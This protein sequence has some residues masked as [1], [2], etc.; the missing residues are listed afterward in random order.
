MVQDVAKGLAEM[1]VEGA[2]L[3]PISLTTGVYRNRVLYT[4]G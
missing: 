1:L 4:G 3:K 2:G